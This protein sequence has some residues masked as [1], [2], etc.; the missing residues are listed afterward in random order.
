MHRRAS[1]GCL[2]L[3]A[4][5]TN[6]V[7]RSALASSRSAYSNSGSKSLWS[8]R[9]CTACA[10]SCA[11]QIVHRYRHCERADQYSDDRGDDGRRHEHLR[12]DPVGPL[13]GFGDFLTWQHKQ[14]N[15]CN[16]W[17]NQQRQKAPVEETPTA[18]SGAIAKRDRNGDPRS[19]SS[20]SIPTC[21]PP[22][23]RKI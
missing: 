10:S 4:R 16:Q 11:P 15:A 7:M 20:T 21:Q 5:S 2:A 22:V 13:F 3:G 18:F 23:R 14:Q 19:R 6:G 9:R 1:L 12:Q 17:R 8:C